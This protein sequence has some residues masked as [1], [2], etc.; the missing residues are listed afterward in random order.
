M[1]IEDRKRRLKNETRCGCKA[2]FHVFFEVAKGLWRLTK[3]KPNYNHDLPA[4][5]HLYYLRS[6]RQISKVQVSQLEIRKMVRLCT[7]DIINLMVHHTGRTQH[8]SFTKKDGYNKLVAIEHGQNID[9]DSEQLLGYLA[10]RID[11]IDPNMYVRYAIDDQDRLCHLFRSNGTSQRD[12]R[13]FSNALAFDTTY[14]TN[15]F[16]KPLVIFIGVNNHFKTSVFQF[17]LL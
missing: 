6:N 15:A 16:N 14:R 12:Y 17:G 10:S 9:N 7:C 2:C 13:Y 8:V 1:N 5:H 11:T 4:Q 3:F